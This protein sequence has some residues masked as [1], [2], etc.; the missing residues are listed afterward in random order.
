MWFNLE[1]TCDSKVVGAEIPNH[2]NGNS[3]ICEDDS[4]PILVS[5]PSYDENATTHKI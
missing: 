2:I 1:H 3:T 5:R 4:S